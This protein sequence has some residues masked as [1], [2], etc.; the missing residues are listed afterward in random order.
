MEQLKGIQV[1]GIFPIVGPINSD[2][3]KKKWTVP[4]CFTTTLPTRQKLY[5]SYAL[6]TQY[7]WSHYIFHSFQPNLRPKHRNSFVLTR[8][9]EICSFWLTSKLPDDKQPELQATTLTFH[10]PRLCAASSPSHPSEKLSLTCHPLSLLTVAPRRNANPS[11]SLVLLRLF[12]SAP[13]F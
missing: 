6:Q 10:R 13:I 5:G 11:L 3:Y 2:W 4:S 1:E 8:T 9:K 12:Q 7:R